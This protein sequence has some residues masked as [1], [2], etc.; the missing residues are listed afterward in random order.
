ML[1][2]ALLIDYP[3][4]GCFFRIIRS[5]EWCVRGGQDNALVPLL[6]SFCMSH[7][8]P[9]TQ[10]FFF[11]GLII[12]WLI[13]LSSWA[14]L[15]GQRDRNANIWFVGITLYSV[16]VS[17][18]VVSP[19]FPQWVRGPLISGLSGLSVLCLLESLR[20]ELAPA[21]LPWKRY[22]A[23]ALMWFL[24]ILGIFELDD[25]EAM[26]RGLH[27]VLISGVEFYVVWTANQVRRVHHSRAMWILMLTISTFALSNLSRV[28]EYLLNGEFSLLQDF[29][30]PGRFALVMNYLSAIFYCYGYWGFVVEKSRKK[31]I[32]AAE[33][34]VLA[35]EAEN[36]ALARES[37]MQEVLQERTALLGRLS[38][39]GKMAQSGALSATIAHEVNQPLTSIR[40]SAEQALHVATLSQADTRLKEQLVRIEEE[41]KRAADI[42]YRLRAMFSQ[43]ESQ[44]QAVVIDEVVRFVADLMRDRLEQDRIALRLELGSPGPVSFS[45]GEFEH[46][47]MNLLENAQHALLKSD[48]KDRSIEVRTWQTNERVMLSVRDNGT[49]IEPALLGHV[50]D[51]TV[52]SK[53]DGLGLGLWLSRYIVER[54]GGSIKVDTQVSDGACFVLAFPQ[55]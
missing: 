55:N 47:L 4:K 29:T 5:Y 30:L 54:H 42:V 19:Y 46:V 20:Q 17:L 3:T 6:E 33:E 52:T 48:R 13:P 44:Q 37:L 36:L 9:G 43:K 14:M 31:M 35:R 7:L 41:T 51:L 45:A 39:I 12:F 38:A 50:F 15:Q 1:L 10:L 16:V 23:L 34:S 49:G 18:F 22:A 8:N 21:P 26:G 11:S 24:L 53:D 2:S 40:L 27:L 28:A 25:G 32:A